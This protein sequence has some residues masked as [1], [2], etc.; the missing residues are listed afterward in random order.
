VTGKAITVQVQQV[1]VPQVQLVGEPLA[2]AANWPALVPA[3]TQLALTLLLAQPLQ[4]DVDVQAALQQV[5]TLPFQ[6]ELVGL[7]SAGQ[8]GW[9]QIGIGLDPPPSKGAP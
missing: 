1:A 5:L 2:P 4:V 6:A 8:G 3:V 7:R 9:L